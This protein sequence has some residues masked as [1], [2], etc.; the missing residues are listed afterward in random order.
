MSYNYDPRIVTDGVV[1]YLDAGNPKIYPSTGTVRV[2]GR[3]GL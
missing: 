3:F 2:R 1:L